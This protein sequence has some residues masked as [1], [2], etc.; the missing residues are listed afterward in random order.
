MIYNLY[1]VRF[2]RKDGQH[3]LSSGPPKYK[4]QIHE[5]CKLS[6]KAQSNIT[7]YWKQ[8][9]RGESEISL[10][11]KTKNSETTPHTSPY[12][13]SR[14][15]SPLCWRHS[16]ANYSLDNKLTDLLRT[17]YKY[18][19]RY[20]YD[21]AF[22]WETSAP[23]QFEDRLYRYG[24]LRHKDEVVRRSYIYNVNPYTG[25][26][27]PLPPPRKLFKSNLF[28]SNLNL[29]R[30]LSWQSTGMVKI[31]ITGIFQDPFTNMV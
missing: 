3:C 5:Y 11:I 19:K 30:I 13:A 22:L 26:A 6:I 8:H 16:C 31:G 12:R 15:V 27:T 21:G 4:T 18:S 23:S 28:K 2:W 20:M 17:Q 25:K 9:E 14:G 10:K 7:W 1:V 24:D 29:I